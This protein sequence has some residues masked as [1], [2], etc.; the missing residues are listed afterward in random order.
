MAA[1]CTSTWCGMVSKALTKSSSP[2]ACSSPVNAAASAAKLSCQE[3]LCALELLQLPL[4]V[5]KLVSIRLGCLGNLVL[6]RLGGGQLLPEGLAPSL[7]GIAFLQLRIDLHHGGLVATEVGA[8]AFAPPW[9]HGLISSEVALELL[10]LGF[11]G[12]ELVAGFLR[13]VLHGDICLL[14]CR[15]CGSGLGAG[16][17]LVLGL[18]EDLKLQCH[19]LPLLLDSF[20]L[21]PQGGLAR[22]LWLGTLPL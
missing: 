14:R 19:L 20:K 9:L 15:P 11:D 4:H 6:V 2:C 5:C 17:S 10:D 16:S 18:P 1:A 13:L 22:V 7:A 12:C 21:L 8:E 3:A